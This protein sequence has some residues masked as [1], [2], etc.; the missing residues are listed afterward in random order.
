VILIE[1]WPSEINL[2]KCERKQSVLFFAYRKFLIFYRAIGDG[3]MRKRILTP[4][5]VCI[6][7]MLQGCASLAVQHKTALGGKACSFPLYTYGGTITSLGLMVMTGVEIPKKPS[8]VIGFAMLAA[9]FPLTVAMDTLTLPVSI[10]RDIHACS[11]KDKRK[12]S[13]YSLLNELD[14]NQEITIFLVP[15]NRSDELAMFYKYIDS[16]GV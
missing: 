2:M 8:V 1:L 10:V 14:E 16:T 3:T 13:Q 11:K 6:V 12:N 15:A 9:D 7:I 4:L 5:V